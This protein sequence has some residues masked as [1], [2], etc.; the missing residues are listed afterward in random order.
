MKHELADINGIRMHYVTHGA[1]KPILF[2]HGF[3]EY[4]GVWKQLMAEFG[5]DHLVIAPDLRGYGQSSKPAEVEQYRIET[6]VG[7]VKG[8]LNHLGLKKVTLVAQD[9]GAFL[10]CSYV[11]RHPEYVERYVAVDVTHPAIFNRELQQNPKQQELSAYMLAFGTSQAEAMVAANDYAW[12]RQAV[13]DDA[14]AH[15]AELSEAD[16]AEWLDTWKQPGGVTGGLNYY[17]AARMGPPAG[18]GSTGGSNLVDGLSPEQLKAKVPVLLLWGEKDPYFTPGSL[19]GLEQYVPQLT[20]RKLP[21]A[22]HWVTLEKR[23]QV[24]GYLREFLGAKG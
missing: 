1:G 12:P 4:W 8:L 3:P 23:A 13:F 14:R 7:D 10:G 15:G 16:M 20:V 21:D 11:L 22:T 18:P 17:R 2:L 6:L 24:T 5:K 9:W 19:D